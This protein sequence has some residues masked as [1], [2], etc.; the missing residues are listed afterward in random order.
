MINQEKN[1]GL[2]APPP[3]S[4]PA[5]KRLCAWAQN[6]WQLELWSHT[7]VDLGSSVHWLITW[8]LV[9]R[10]P[11]MF[12]LVCIDW[13]SRQIAGG[14]WNRHLKLSVVLWKAALFLQLHLRG[15]RKSKRQRAGWPLT[16]G[17]LPSSVKPGR[18]FRKSPAGFPNQSSELMEPFWGGERRWADSG[19]PAPLIYV[20]SSML[21]GAIKGEDHI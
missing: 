8:R 12:F 7:L 5:E 19:R 6:E 3:S 16:L 18:C 14:S 13:P 15:C 11:A 2:H 9:L 4:G 20:Q 10:A 21:K 17:F 1:P